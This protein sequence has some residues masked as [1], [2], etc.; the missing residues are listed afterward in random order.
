MFSLDAFIDAPTIEE[1]SSVNRDELV[2]ISG[3]YRVDVHG[4]PTKAE[5][6]SK[7][8]EVLTAQGVF[9]DV[10]KGPEEVTKPGSLGSPAAPGRSTTPPISKAE[11]ELR[12]LELREKEIEWEREK[13]RLEG[14]RQTVRERDRMEH[15]FKMKDLELAKAIRLKELEIQAREAGVKISTDHFDVVRNVRLVPPFN[16]KEVDK[17]FA[18][19]ERVAT[20]LKWPLGVWTMLLQSIL[21]GKAQQAYSSLPL[22]DAADYQKVKQAVLRIYSLVPEA[23]R[24]NYRNYKKPD[25]LTHVEFMREKEFLCD[26]WL[27]SQE[28]TTFEG[29]RDL[30][31]L[32]DFKNCLSRSVA[33]Y[34]SEHKDLKPASAAVLADEYVL[35]HKGAISCPVM[36]QNSMPQTSFRTPKEPVGETHQADDYRETRPTDSIFCGY[37]KKPGHVLSDCLTLKRKNRLQ[38]TGS[39][40]AGSNMGLC[41]STLPTSRKDEN[42]CQAFAPFIT[43]GFVTLPGAPGTEVPIRIIRDTAASQ[44]FILENVLPFSDQSYTGEDVLVQGFEM[45]FVNVPLHDVSLLSD[46]VTGD[47]KVG[48]RP[49]L[50]IENVQVLLGND[51]MGGV[52]FSSPVMTNSPISPGPDELDVKFPEVFHANV[53]TRAMAQTAKE[54]AVSGSND[55]VVDLSE[56]FMAHPLPCTS[57]ENEKAS[58][59]APLSFVPCG[60]KLS[61]SREQ[62]IVEQRNDSSLSSLLT[63]AVSEKDIES[64]PQGYFIREGVLMRKWR[65]LT[66]SASDVWRVLHQIVVP[67]PYRDEVLR[68]GHDQH[69]SSHLGINKTSDR[70]LRHFFW[71]GL[72]RDVAHYCKTCHICQVTGKPNQRIPP[73]PLQPIPVTSEPF[74]HIILDCVGPLPRTKTGKEYLLTIMCTLTRFPEAIPLGRI[75]APAV[76]KALVGFFSHFGLPKIVQTDQGTN[77]MSKMFKQAMQQLGIK[78]ITSSCYHPQTQGALERF[79]QTFKSMLRAFCLEFARDWDEGVPFSLFAVREVVQE[80]LGFS[81][82]ELVFGHSVRGP[83]KLLKESWLTANTSYRSLSD[84]VSKIRCRLHRACEL[85]RENLGVCQKRMKQRYDKNAVVR[86]FTPGDQAM[87]LLPILGSAL[88]ARYSGPYRVERRVGD[89]NYVIATPDRRKKSRVGHINMLKRYCERDG[90][91]AVQPSTCVGSSGGS[92]DNAIDPELPL[93]ITPGAE[94]VAALPVAVRPGASTPLLSGPTASPFEDEDVRSPSMEVVVGRM[95]NSE[96]LTDLNSYFSHLSDSERDDLISLIASYDNLFSDVPGRTTAITHDIDVGD[97]R[98]IKQHAYRANPLKLSQLQKEVKFMVDHG[99][100]EP[101]FSPW[102]SPCILVSK[103][104]GTFRFCTDFRKVNAVTKPDSFPLPRMD[105][106]VDRIG[107]AVFVSKIDLLKGYWQIPLT[108]RAKEISAFVT[109][110][111]FLQYNVLPFGLRNA[112][113]SFQRLVNY[114]LADVSNCEAY[115]DN[116]VI[117]STTWQDHVGHLKSVLERLS[118]ANLT[119][120]LAKCE[121][122][123]ATVVYLGKVVGGG[124]VRPVHSKIEAV[125]NYPPPA[126]RRELRCFLGMVGYYRSFCKNFSAVATLLTDLLSPKRPFVWTE[127][128]Q[129][130]FESVKALLTTA[131]VLAAPNFSIP[132]SLAVD[133]SDLGAGGV[134]MQCG[135]NG[136]EHPL[137]FFSRKFN[138]HQRGYST[139]EK[140]ALALVLAL[141]HFEVYVGGAAQ[142]VTVYTDHNPLTFLDRMRNHNQRLMRWSLLLQ[143]FNLNIQHIRGRE[144]VVADALSRA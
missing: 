27:N 104:D 66:A 111:R 25:S 115:L 89:V 33:M 6:L 95:K 24:Q 16:E 59:S 12:R 28:V 73:A 143:G 35:A 51:I 46:L 19:F 31:I 82:S 41:V 18:H 9:G 71:P 23:Y 92:N 45:G 68:L 13:S 140:E 70:I 48:V 61:L 121:F 109:P 98:P 36:F 127:E 67:L 65:P 22:E 79:H 8:M 17:F 99:I 135:T 91:S 76:I 124:Q 117:Y 139:I 106:C 39:P 57:G 7:L 4:R 108:E 74:E 1:L 43:D 38:S 69:F 60:P 138:C 40:R 34:V 113:A 2:L 136:L 78:H 42:I 128:S 137:C 62:L 55:E 83:L 5:L 123:R 29:L 90:T 84:Y 10:G 112:P 11:I 133:A 102:S 56:T 116:L 54:T 32:E 120:N 101:S 141:Q 52:V 105:D 97:S 15:E 103:S 81:P 118:A 49:H 96:V 37:C 26:R 14:D 119:I 86:E 72:R 47:F 44:S 131:P 80:S 94:T 88:Q 64:T 87:V 77:F 142:P 75:T 110:D 107:S 126:S 50:P 3:H 122:G 129:L 58:K 20:V 63:D 53:F 144:N 125:L 93:S 132:F 100:A 21:V 85:A 30:V 130:A 114:V 134:L